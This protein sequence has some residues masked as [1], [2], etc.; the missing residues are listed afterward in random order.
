MYFNREGLSNSFLKVHLAAI[1]VYHVLVDG[2]QLFV[3]N[4][5]KKFRN[6]V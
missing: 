5:D 4:M 2:R 3:H 1:S 6:K